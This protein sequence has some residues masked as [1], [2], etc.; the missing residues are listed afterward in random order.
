MIEN[1][2]ERYLFSVHLSGGK[3]NDISAQKAKEIA[4]KIISKYYE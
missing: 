2:S 1:G 4:L 3:G